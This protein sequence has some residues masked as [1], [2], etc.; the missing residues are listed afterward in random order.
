MPPLPE[1][2]LSIEKLCNRFPLSGKIELHKHRGVL[3][4]V[5]EVDGFTFVLLRCHGSAHTKVPLI[6]ARGGI[7]LVV[8]EEKTVKSISYCLGSFFHFSKKWLIDA[9]LQAAS[10]RKEILC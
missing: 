4:D 3:R 6:R 10:L 2:I 5:R 9:S 1:G 8:K 7:K